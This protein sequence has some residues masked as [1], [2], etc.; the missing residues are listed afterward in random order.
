MALLGLLLLSGAHAQTLRHDQI[1][2]G[3]FLVAPRKALDP[4]FAE[5]VV[6][7]VQYDEESTMGLI[8]NQ[9]SRGNVAQ[10]FP[11]RKALVSERVFIGGPVGRS[12]ML[13]L[14]RS[15]T[16]PPDAEHIFA[17][18]YLVADKKL[19]DK[20]LVPG[21]ENKNFRVYLGYTGWAPG[22]LEEE[23][24]NDLW[25]LFDGD[26]RAVFDPAPENI[27]PRLVRLTELN[28]ARVFPNPVRNALYRKYK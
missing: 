1:A 22:Q 17:N 25:H 18:I 7:I 2:P 24:N 8:I 5:T 19:F 3:T 28:I 15:K 14:L 23:L 27:W 26:P 21:A 16:K 4:N 11:K 13:G 10:L 9:P 12:G 20:S 6:L